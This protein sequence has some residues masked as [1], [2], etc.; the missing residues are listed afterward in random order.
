MALS[1]GLSLNASLV[2][3]IQNQC[4]LANYIISVERVNQYM[5]IQSEAE[6]I[7]EDNRPPLNWPVAGKVEINDLKVI[8]TYFQN[9]KHNF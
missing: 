4:T 7:V 3:S 2:F 6:E 9:T 8:L 1:Y 5:H